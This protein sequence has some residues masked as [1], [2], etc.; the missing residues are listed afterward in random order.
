MLR[1]LGNH[2]P[3]CGG[4]HLFSGFLKVSAE[5]PQCG[6]PL[7]RV[8]AD[9]V[10]PYFTILIVGHIVVPL[11]LMTDRQWTPPVWLDALIFVPLT[12]ALC[13]GLLRPVKGATVGLM[14]KL[15]M[16]RAIGDA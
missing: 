13:L 3:A 15:G 6:A 9:D 7:G 11:M 8:R 16:V 1:G 14:L 5:C 4:S 12:L 10:P 2:C